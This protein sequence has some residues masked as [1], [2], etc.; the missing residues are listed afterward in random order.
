[1][2][3]EWR[4]IPGYEGIY[5]ASDAGRVRSLNR[6]NTYGRRV[7]GRILKQQTGQRGRKQVD[8][9]SG[10]SRRMA[11]VHQLVL[12]AFV[13]PIPNGM[14]DVRHM[15]GDAS[16]NCLENLRYGTRAE[17]QQDSLRHGTQKERRKTHCPRG[18]MLID[19]NLDPGRAA[20]GHRI[21]LACRKECKRAWR[22]GETFSC[23]SA[24][25]Y[26]AEITTT[27]ITTTAAAAA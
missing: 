6:V 3:E 2:S 18:H 19:P 10:A 27:T 9:L 20:R 25:R 14:T 21:C 15:N 22:K 26:Y 24:D 8:L 13:G 23:D 4:A 1:M 7:V 17:N 5:E 11:F 16:D 12:E